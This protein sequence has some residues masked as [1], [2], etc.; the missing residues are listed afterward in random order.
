MILAI[1]SLM[2]MN[3]Y[4]QTLILFETYVNCKIFFFVSIKLENVL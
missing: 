3:S 1:S 2:Y 4:L